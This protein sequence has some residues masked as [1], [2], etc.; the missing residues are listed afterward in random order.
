MLSVKGC[1]GSVEYPLEALVHIHVL[2]MVTQVSSRPFAKQQ[3][4][5][6]KHMTLHCTGSAARYWQYL[7]RQFDLDLLTVI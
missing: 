1:G 6:V 3:K 2:Y 4:M 7:T 5:L